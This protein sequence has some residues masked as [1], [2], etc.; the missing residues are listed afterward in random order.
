ML[1]KHSFV[2][3]ASA[4]LLTA[5]CGCAV[6]PN[7][8]T[9]T[10][11][12]MP[13]VWSHTEEFGP[14]GPASLP[15]GAPTSRYSGLTGGPAKVA[16]WWKT[17]KDPKLDSLIE[18]AIRSNLDLKVAAARIRESR[19]QRG[20]AFAGL[21]PTVNSSA[22]YAY[23]GHSVNA[24]EQPKTPGPLG[25][26]TGILSKLPVLN[27]KPSTTGGLPVI[28]LSPNAGGG[29]SGGS[30]ASVSVDRDQNLYQAGFDATWELDVFGGIRRGVESADDNIAAAEWNW[31]DT[32]VTLL[33]EVARN[34]VD[35]RSFQR[36]IAIANQNIVSQR[37]T[38]NLTRTRFKAGLT[39]ELDVVRAEAQLATT[40]SA[41]PT[42]ETSLIQVIHQLG[43]LLGQPPETL[44]AE[45]STEAPI[46]PVP[47]EVPAGLPSDLLRRRPDVRRAERQL[48]SATAL[49]GQAMAEL[50]PT[51]SLTGSFGWTSAEANKLFKARSD[52]WS[53]GPGVQ[54]PIFEGGRIMAN[55]ELQNAFQEEAMATY[56]STV[57]TA[58]Q[59]VENSLIAY[60]QE[61]IRYRQLTQAV[62]SNRRAVVLSN[63]LYSKGLADFLSVLVAQA[64]QYATE[65]ALAQSEGFVVDNLIAIYKALGGGWEN[66][67]ENENES[68]AK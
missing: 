54:W 8:E 6:G 5:A 32:L 30:G 18:R 58:L 42:L 35:C 48:A 26:T 36:R 62:T 11:C 16:R 23:T 46:P 55:I 34:Y 9:P 28:T 22:S 3:R 60:S 15:A 43:V 17:L 61:K 2:F 45:L 52:N 59:D 14:P 47:P 63:E 7:Y 40:E 24:T 10:P 49:I 41:V 21:L 20:I 56:S 37:E 25:G 39:G 65:D 27:V 64:S 19:A 38:L 1:R 50:F 68:E 4:G 51:F 57:L 66:E 53:V 44:L 29:G 31:R 33:S 12:T 67:N 13:A